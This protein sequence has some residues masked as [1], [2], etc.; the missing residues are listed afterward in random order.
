[1]TVADLKRNALGKVFILQQTGIHKDGLAPRL[2]GERKCVKVQSNALAFSN[3]EIQS[4]L[5]LPKASLIEYTG[6]ELK[7]YKPG[8]REPNAE[9][10]KALKEWEEIESTDEYRKQQQEDAYTDG[11]QCYYKEKS[12]FKSRKMEYLMGLHEERGLYLDMHRKYNGLSDFI[13]DAKIKGEL[14][15]AYTIKEA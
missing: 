9:E 12:F 10:R 13:R 3:G 5:Y 2:R 15:L 4:Y 7:T 11:S 8:Y 14:E 1:M 6:T